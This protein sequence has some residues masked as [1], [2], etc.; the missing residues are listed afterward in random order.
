MCLVGAWLH[1][2]PRE[3]L[4]EVVETGRVERD[5]AGLG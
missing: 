5:E 1:P 2:V 3:R 4:L